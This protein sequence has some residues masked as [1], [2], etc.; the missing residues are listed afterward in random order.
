MKQFALIVAGAL[1]AAG[2]IYVARM[3]VDRAVADAEL[4]ADMERFRLQ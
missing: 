1:V 4:L 2:L 3:L